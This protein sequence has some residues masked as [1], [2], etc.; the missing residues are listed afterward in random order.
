MH[1]LGIIE[2]DWFMWKTQL[3]KR[4]EDKYIENF[5]Q[6]YQICLGRTPRCGICLILGKSKDTEHYSYSTVYFDVLYDGMIFTISA[7]A[8][9][10]IEDYEL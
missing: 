8:I 4:V 9:K 3:N 10:K 7:D 5:N 2:Q 1:R 6:V